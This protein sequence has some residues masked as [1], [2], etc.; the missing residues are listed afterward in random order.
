MLEEKIRKDLLNALKEK[1]TLEAGALRLL[2]AEIRNRR[3]QKQEELSEEDILAV[4][5]QQVKLR[6]EAIAAYQKGNREDLVRKEQEELNILSKYLPQ[7][8]SPEE[9]RKIIQETIS[10]VGA[11]G[12]QDFGRVMGAVMGKVKGRAEGELVAQTVRSL[13]N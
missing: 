7:Q 9:L 13:L 4:I 2:L 6:R 5:R 3:L 12:P 8:I 11:S 1:R 10:Q